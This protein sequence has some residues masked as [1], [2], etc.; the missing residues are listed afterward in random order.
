MKESVRMVRAD[1]LEILV[2]G[3][4]VR[5]GVHD[6]WHMEWLGEV[7]TNVLCRAGFSVVVEDLIHMI[8]DEL[9]DQ[10]LHSHLQESCIPIAANCLNLLW[11]AWGKKQ[12]S[13]QYCHTQP[14]GRKD[15]LSSCKPWNR[16][17]FP[18]LAVPLALFPSQ[19]LILSLP[20]Q[21]FWNYFPCFLCHLCYF[22][23]CLCYFPYLAFMFFS[24]TQNC[25]SQTPFFSLFAALLAIS[26]FGLKDNIGAFKYCFQILTQ[27]FSHLSVKSLRSLHRSSLSQFFQHFAVCPSSIFSTRLHSH[28]LTL[29]LS[30]ET[31]LIL[32]CQ[33]VAEEII[34]GQWIL[35][36]VKDW[37]VR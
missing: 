6:K 1:V 15:E 32:T 14:L 13:T 22:L 19:A 9:D 24:S 27:C 31:F 2:E 30:K 12:T 37:C 11:P 16:D 34:S 3:D 5:A 4:T 18:T 35:C 28:I 26:K 29:A 33:S 21:S 17:V 10:L 8:Q 36:K 25:D 23:S 7:V 20:F